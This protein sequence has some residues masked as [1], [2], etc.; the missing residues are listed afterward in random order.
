MTVHFILASGIQK[1]KL[2]DEAFSD[3]HDEG[4]TWNYK[5]PSLFS[6]LKTA[7]NVWMLA[8]M[9]ACAL[10]VW[11]VHGG[12]ERMWDSLGLALTNGCEQPYRCWEWNLGPLEEQSML[13]TT[14]P[15]YFNKKRCGELVLYLRWF[16]TEPNKWISLQ[17][18]RR[19]TI[20]P[21][22]L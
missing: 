9:Y 18:N 2:Q 21:P 4:K 16:C 5:N 13:V 1:S 10:C 20:L 22:S 3:T 17:R 11:S 6:F 14:N 15:L 8:C 7:L 19:G 12:Q